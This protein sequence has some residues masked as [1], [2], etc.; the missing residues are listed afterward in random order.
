MRTIRILTASF[1]AAALALGPAI[2]WAQMGTEP[3]PSEPS[4]PAKAAA[5][6]AFPSPS[7]APP[8]TTAPKAPA[9]AA[10][11][12]TKAKAAKATST[13]KSA[14]APAS[15]APASPMPPSAPT[16]SAST[17]PGAVAAPGSAAAPSAP[18]APTPAP[19]LAP[20]PAAMPKTFPYTAFIN[21]DAVNIRS[22][23]GL[24]YYP[25][26]IL[27]S[28]M[29]V[30][31]ESE[32]GAFLAIR[33]PEGVY[34]LIKR[35]DLAMGMDGK[36]ATVAATSA[37]VYAASNAAT[38]QWCVMGTLKQGDKVEVEGTAEGDMVGIAPPAGAHVYVDGRYVTA[39]SSGSKNSDLLSK[40]RG[41]P[42]KADPLM[43]DLKKADGMLAEEQKR[44]I[45]QRDFADAAAAF[46]EIGEKTDKAWLKKIVRQRLGLMV[47]LET[48]QAD[49]RRVNALGE[50]LQKQLA[51]IAAESAAKE[52]ATAREKQL[53]RPEFV[54]TGMIR[55]LESLETVDYPI[56]FKLVDPN[57]H[58]L[59]VLNSSTYDLSKFV[60]KVV[61]IRGAKTWL[62][63]WGIYL[64][65]VDD[66]EELE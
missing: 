50:Q 4:A 17:L 46:R 15:L 55:P 44:P 3:A 52:T 30:A 62:K 28:D 63:P 57:N 45:G 65:T 64:V 8:A 14:P 36:T 7:P 11:K 37:R 12:A 26:A 19:T 2:L 53:A 25:L 22:G 9:K 32:A 23:P 49:Y 54:A 47:Q 29:E 51:E 39:G 66:I 20:A 38:R 24:Y 10:T 35:V 42:P 56:K 18:A 41:E 31:V 61:G 34:G 13:V 40:M 16:P 60:G 5:P 33:P 21:A 43:E 27:N 48:R 59:V 1:V 58:P 6:A